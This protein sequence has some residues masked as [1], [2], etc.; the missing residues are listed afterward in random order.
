MV[1]LTGKCSVLWNAQ[2]G[3]PHV[4]SNMKTK[5]LEIE[6][7]VWVASRFNKNPLVARFKGVGDEPICTCDLCS[8]R[9]CSR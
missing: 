5:I 6:H 2:G 3:E 9:A 4:P 1:M 7:K 8:H